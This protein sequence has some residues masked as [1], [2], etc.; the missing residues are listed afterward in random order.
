MNELIVLT[1]FFVLLFGIY[2]LISVAYPLRPFRTRKRAFV[3]VLGCFVLLM[4]LAAGITPDKH[5]KQTIAKATE[6]ESAKNA[7]E[8]PANTEVVKDE[9]DHKGAALQVATVAEHDLPAPCGHGGVALSDVVAVSDNH[10]LYAEPSVGAAL[11]KNEK[12]SEILKS[13]QFHRID[14]STTVKRLCV[15]EAWTEVQLVEPEWLR[16][17]KGWV[18]NDALRTIETDAAGMRVYVGDDF[19]WNRDTTSYKAQIISIVNRI[20]RE[21]PGCKRIDPSSV[22]LSTNKGGADDPVF[23]VTCGELLDAFNVW[24]K[25]S[26]VDSG[27]AFEPK[28][29]IDRVAAADACEKA[30]KLAATHPS[31]VSFSRLW[32]LAYVPHASGR[33]TVLSSFTAK[34]SFGLEI[35]HRI[36]CLFD[37]PGLI[38]TTIAESL[39]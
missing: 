5:P 2:A 34:N 9:L 30:A 11:V 33:V 22:A 3:T 21:H 7:I 27:T 4:L 15:Q 8:P 14:T 24:F 10:Q 19:P 18:P 1:F 20:A 25:P 35:N 23:Y 37:G 38:G 26:D 17:V 6:P 39:G 28:A 16:H 31:T 12:A 32:D 29:Q 36:K 13:A